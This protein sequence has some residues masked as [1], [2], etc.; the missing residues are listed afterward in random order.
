M[1][2]QQAHPFGDLRIVGGDRAGVAIGAEILA[3][4]EAEARGIAQHADAPSI[5]GRAVRL[6]GIFDEYEIVARCQHRQ[7]VHVGR[8]A[9][10]VDGQDGTRGRSQDGFDRVRVQVVGAGINVGK[11]RACADSADRFGRGNEGVR[12]RHDLVTGADAAR[13]QR[14]FERGR[15]AG[16]AHRVG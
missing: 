2:A 4:V 6:G 8:L 16:D 11:D 15:P 12:G 13:A 14:Q 10:D 5:P 1:V 7:G 9:I 3:G